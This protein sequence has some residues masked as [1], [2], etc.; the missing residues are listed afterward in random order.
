[1]NCKC[2]SG[3]IIGLEKRQEDSLIMNPVLSVVAVCLLVGMCSA[4]TSAS[5]PTREIPDSDRRIAMSGSPFG[6]AGGFPYGYQGVKAYEFIPQLRQLG[7]DFTKVYLFWN[8]IE[9]KKGQYDW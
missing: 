6:I 7:S 3:D 9:P 4:Q 1:M 5:Q 8:Q 2:S